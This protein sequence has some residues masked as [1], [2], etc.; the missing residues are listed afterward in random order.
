[1]K[2]KKQSPPTKIALWTS[3]LFSALATARCSLS[4]NV[5]HCWHW[6]HRKTSTVSKRNNRE[7]QIY[8]NLKFNQPLVDQN[9]I[10][11][12]HELVLFVLGP[13]A[14]LVAVC[15]CARYLTHRSSFTAVACRFIPFLVMPS[16]NLTASSW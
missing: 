15:S 1:M 16:S 9:L 12:F 2:D 11:T 6:L 7:I 8:L 10:L 5:L 3:I 4:E 13:P 14:V